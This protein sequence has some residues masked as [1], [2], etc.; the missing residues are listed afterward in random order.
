[1]PKQ[2]ALTSIENCTSFL[3]AVSSEFSLS[4][5]SH[6][7]YSGFESIEQYSQSTLFIDGLVLVSQ[8]L[9]PIS[10]CRPCLDSKLTRGDNG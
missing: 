3:L 5:S 10:V 2:A 8:N 4:C 7:A 9:N 1:M 6:E